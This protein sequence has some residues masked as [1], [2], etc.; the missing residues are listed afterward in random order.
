MKAQIKN[1]K[2][3]VVLI[4]V[5]KKRTLLLVCFPG[6]TG[7]PSAHYSIA[8]L[9]LFFSLPW[10][11]G[12]LQG[13]NI[14]ISTDGSPAETGVMLDIKEPTAKAT[15]AAVQTFFQIKSFDADNSALKL[16]LGFKTDAAQAN[17]YGFIDFPEYIAGVPTYLNLALQPSGGN[18]GIGT[19]TPSSKLTVGNAGAALNNWVPELLV[20]TPS[21]GHAG[22]AVQYAGTTEAY[23]YADPAGSY[24]GNYTNSD[25]YFLTNDVIRMTIKNGGN[26]GIGTTTPLAGLEVN[27]T[28]A[29]TSSAVSLTGDAQAVTPSTTYIQL[30]SNNATSTSRTIVLANGTRVGQI[31]I[32]HGPAANACELQDSD[33]AS[34][35]DLSGIWT[36]SA[37]A[38]MIIT[39]LWNGTSWLELSRIN[40]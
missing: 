28:T 8:L 24:F 16:R 38:N 1:Q 7:I 3:K 31:L 22:L 35:A 12:M 26:L 2:S 6:A 32:L 40:N 27:A 34:N 11:G 18:V 36:V 39:L 37:D 14:A 33:A 29:F 15:T 21:G 19:S 4:N 13:Q 25:M 9:F 5:R 10:G 23:I 17:R 30:S 20:S